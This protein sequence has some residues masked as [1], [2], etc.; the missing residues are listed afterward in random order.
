MNATRHNPIR[1]S[2]VSP[3]PYQINEDCYI[4][5]RKHTLCFGGSDK[6]YQVIDGFIGRTRWPEVN[7]RSLFGKSIYIYFIFNLSMGH[8]TFDYVV[9]TKTIYII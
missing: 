3:S 5:E 4:A 6:L 9:A 1:T 7:F 2:L 8:I